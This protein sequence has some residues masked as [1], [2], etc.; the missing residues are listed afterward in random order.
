MVVFHLCMLINPPS[1]NVLLAKSL[2]WKHLFCKFVLKTFILQKLTLKAFLLQKLKNFFFNFSKMYQI[3]FQIFFYYF[4]FFLKK[5]STFFFTQ[6]LYGNRATVSVLWR[7]H[8]PITSFGFW[9]LECLTLS[10]KNWR[11]KKFI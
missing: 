6:H 1:K 3:I 7:S 10:K 11:L 5:S 4:L 2:F 9:F 8:I